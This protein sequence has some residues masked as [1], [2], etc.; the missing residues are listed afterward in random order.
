MTVKFIKGKK[1]ELVIF[2]DDIVTE[3]IS[4]MELDVEGLHSLMRS[5]GFPKK[6]IV[7][8]EEEEE[9]EAVVEEGEVKGSEL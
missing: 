2:D 9:E 8:V 5:K 6:E 1:P 7:E 4:L 3:R